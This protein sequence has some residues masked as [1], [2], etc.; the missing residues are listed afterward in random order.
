MRI[1]LPKCLSSRATRE[2][3]LS[4]KT[5]FVTFHHPSGKRNFW[6]LVQGSRYIF[7]LRQSKKK[8]VLKINGRKY[9]LSSYFCWSRRWSSLICIWTLMNIQPVEEENAEFSNWENFLL[10]YTR[11]SKL[12]WKL[13]L[14]PSSQKVVKIYRLV[15]WITGIS[16]WS[17]FWL[18]ST[19]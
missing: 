1:R 14:W 13:Y 11:S 2:F 16:M 12:K 7:S 3:F 15:P 4:T 19:S 9:L 6:R 8:I 10:E 17:L 18:H 5:S